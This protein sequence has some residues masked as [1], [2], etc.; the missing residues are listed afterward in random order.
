[1][2]Q[3]NLLKEQAS[4][5]RMPDFEFLHLFLPILRFNMFISTRRASEIETKYKYALKEKTVYYIF[6]LLKL[7]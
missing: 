6:Q 2:T 7:K 3:C 4:T 1:M 5:I